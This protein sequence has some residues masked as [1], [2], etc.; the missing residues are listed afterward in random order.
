ML[1]TKISLAIAVILGI[2]LYFVLPPVN[3]FIY[4]TIPAVII[5]NVIRIVV[6]KK[7]EK[8]A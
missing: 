7:Q 8:Y 2:C 1:I 5:V 4:F 3:F 6:K